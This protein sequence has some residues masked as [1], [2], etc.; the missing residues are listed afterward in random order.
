MAGDRKIKKISVI[1]IILTIFF[2][3]S[4]IPLAGCTRQEAASE[5]T[6]NDSSQQL[7]IYRDSILV[8]TD[9]SYPPFEFTEDSTI[10]GFDIDIALEIASRLEKELELVNIDWDFTYKIPEDVRLDMII[11]AVSAAEDRDELVDFSAPYYIMEYML[12][13][14]SDA[15][16]KI[17]EDLKGKKIGMIDSGVKY[18]AADYLKDYTIEE[19][20][21]VLVMLDELKSKNIDG[22]L[23]S[24][25]VGKNII[26]ENAGAY[27]VLEIIKSE[28][29]FSIVFNEGSPLRNKVNDILLEMQEDGTYQKIYDDWFSLDSQNP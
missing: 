21:E 13:V 12:I 5:D 18:I 10:K 26:K 4:S 19:Y 22:I 29:S 17:K 14:L 1:F 28:R 27:R 2:S 6:V 23:I 15:K 8:G 20:K 25:P 24:L 11:S 7:T 3:V 9:A 16:L